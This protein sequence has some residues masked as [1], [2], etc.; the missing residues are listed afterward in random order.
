MS[1]RRRTPVHADMPAFLG[2]GND[3]TIRGLQHATDICE[4]FGNQFPRLTR[5]EKNTDL[6][7]QVG[8]RNISFVNLSCEPTDTGV[9][10]EVR[11]S[12]LLPRTLF[13]TLH[14]PQR[15]I[16]APDS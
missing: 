9:R 7:M 16:S 2:D 11:A 6:D 14:P 4:E 13:A 1:S 3:T 12:C 5:Y 15:G 8:R 10:L